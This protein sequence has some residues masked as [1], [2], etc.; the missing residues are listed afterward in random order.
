[1][2]VQTQIQV[3]RGTAA[4]WTSTNPT[5]AAGEIGFETDTGKYKIG[6]GSSTW[7]AL[8]YNL[9]GATA[10]A[11]PLSTVTTKGDLIGAT[12]SAAVSRVAVGTDGQYL[13]ADST[14][15][16]GVSWTTAPFDITKATAPT[17]TLNSSGATSIPN[18]VKFVY[19]LAVGGGGGGCASGGGG[20][21]IAFGLVAS[22][23]NANVASGG[24]GNIANVNSNIIGPGTAGGTTQLGNIYASG[25]AGGRLQGSNSP[26]SGGAG[27]GASHASGMGAGSGGQSAANNASATIG[28]NGSGNLASTGTGGGGGGAVANNPTGAAGGNGIGGSGAAGF[29]NAGGGGAGY[30]NAGSVGSGSGNTAIGGAGGN[31]GGGGG[32]GASSG[33]GGNGG[34]GVIYIYY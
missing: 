30:L 24:I 7:N 32:G 28:N 12:G 23:A 22:A 4:S 31:G 8:S 26:Q 10:A 33:T 21:G 3:R 20:G 34:N 17:T 9:N 19:V 14:A 25:G 1:M 29:G 27:G 16:A 13:K 2:A 5:L 6:T 18:N 11:I 15:N